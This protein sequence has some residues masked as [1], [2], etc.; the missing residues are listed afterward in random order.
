MTRD[1]ILSL[2]ARRQDAWRRRDAVAL[3]ADHSEDCTMISPMAGIVSGR[4]A[5]GNVY[6][7]WL[8]GFPDF[9]LQDEE[10]L[11]DGDRVVQISTASGTDTGGFMGLP[12]SGKAF[13]IPTVF[14]YQLRDGKIVRFRTIYD[15]TGVLVQIGMLKAK[16]V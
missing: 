7:V 9:T 13:R 4:G 8:T 11:V 12:P 16:P 3:S 1:D 6:S 15:F 2:F 5:I 10:L 14:L